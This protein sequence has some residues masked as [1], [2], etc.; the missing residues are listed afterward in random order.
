MGIMHTPCDS[1]TAFTKSPEVS[2][3]HAAE[4]VS[5]WGIPAIDVLLLAD[6]TWD[7]QMS[8]AVSATTTFLL[9]LVYFM[10]LNI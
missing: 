7:K 6:S 2:S 1:F 3:S 10:I 9:K 4:I 8:K 5:F